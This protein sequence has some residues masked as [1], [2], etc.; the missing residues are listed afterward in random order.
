MFARANRS[1]VALSPIA[2]A[3]AHDVEKECGPELLQKFGTHTCACTGLMHTSKAKTSVGIHDMVP[4]AQCIVSF[5]VTFPT[6]STN[7]RHQHRST[8]NININTGGGFGCAASGEGLSEPLGR[9]PGADDAGGGGAL[10]AHPDGTRPEPC[11]CHSWHSVRGCTVDRMAAKNEDAEIFPE[12]SNTTEPLASHEWYKRDAF[13][14]RSW[15]VSGML[16][17][18]PH[19]ADDKRAGSRAWVHRDRD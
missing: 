1:M 12:F 4:C 5:H 3:A 19:R 17:P 10:N 14:F 6:I 18:P 13:L 9:L 2:G 16:R 7:I 8:R 15:R 11:T